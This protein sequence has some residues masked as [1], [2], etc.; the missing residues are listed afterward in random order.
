MGFIGRAQSDPL[1]GTRDWTRVEV[2]VPTM[3]PY[4]YF[5]RVLLSATPGSTGTAWFDD[6]E[7]EE[8]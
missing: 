4:V 2:E 5:C 8:I 3:Y 6:V 1:D 7:V